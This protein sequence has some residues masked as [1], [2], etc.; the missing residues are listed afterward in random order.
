MH[1][2]D[3][4]LL[5]LLRGCLLPCLQLCC[6]ALW[7]LWHVQGSA[8]SLCHCQRLLW[9]LLPGCVLWRLL[10][11]WGC[12]QQHA[13]HG[14]V[15]WRSLHSSAALWQGLLDDSHQ[16]CKHQ[17]VNAGRLAE[18]LLAVQLLWMLAALAA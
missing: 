1:Q 2:L 16:P 13:L 3:W 9:H 17:A 6:A 12:L 4:L 11:C 18:G 5:H 10:H 14:W 7:L 15:L 8:G